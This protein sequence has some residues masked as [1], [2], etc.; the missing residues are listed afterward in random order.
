MPLEELKVTLDVRP[1][2]TVIRVS[3]A[4][5]HAQYYQLEEAIQTQLDRKV[6]R[7]VVDLAALSYIA[8]AGIN[9]LGHAVSQFE[10][11]KGRL[12]FV[13]PAQTA[14]WHFFTTIGVDRIFPWAATL[15]EALR[16]IAS[17]PLP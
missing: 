4:V 15:D 16:K 14:Q 9:T 7:L 5:D 3:G 12:L 6:L 1:G 13:R 17:E 8:S 2:V 11:L 10:K